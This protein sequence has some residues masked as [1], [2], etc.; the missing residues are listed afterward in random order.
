M[1]ATHNEI[2]GN[3]TCNLKHEDDNYYQ[4]YIETKEGATSFEKKKPKKQGSAKKEIGDM[5]KNSNGRL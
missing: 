5:K 4:R 1:S 3:L 2:K